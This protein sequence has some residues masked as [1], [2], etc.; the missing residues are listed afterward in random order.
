MVEGESRVPIVAVFHIRVVR[1]CA[2]P[3]PYMYT[4]AEVNRSARNEGNVRIKLQSWPLKSRIFSALLLH[5]R[6]APVSCAL[7][8]LRLEGTPVCIRSLALHRAP[9]HA[10]PPPHP[11]LVSLACG[12]QLHTVQKYQ[13]ENCRK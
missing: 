10:S 13:V 11:A 5:D 4:D 7:G 8:D 6:L 12:F 9:P 2:L 3:S 1:Y